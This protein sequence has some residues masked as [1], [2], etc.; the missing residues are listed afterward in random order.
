MT[1]RCTALCGVDALDDRYSQSR[2][3]EIDVIAV[4]IVHSLNRM[5]LLDSLTD[6]MVDV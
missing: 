2:P 4:K 1:D 5:D 3:I 6:E